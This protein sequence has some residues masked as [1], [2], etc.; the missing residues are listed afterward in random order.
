MGQKGIGTGVARPFNPAAFHVPASIR[1]DERKLKAAIMLGE[2]AGLEMGFEAVAAECGVSYRTLFD[3]RQD[4]DFQEAMA[5][6][7]R[8]SLKD[9]MPGAYKTLISLLKSKD[10]KLKLR[11]A[12]L[13]FKI[14]GELVERT[15]VT[16][17]VKHDAKSILSGLAREIESME[18]GEV[19]EVGSLPEPKALPAPDNSESVPDMMEAVG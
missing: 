8:K 13:A 1:N 5:I 16:A 14:T 12:E 7:M 9:V 18:V 15:E 2:G 17:T 19:V 10:P 6:I 4:D 11:A 3:W